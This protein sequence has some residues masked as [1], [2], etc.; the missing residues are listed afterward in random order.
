MEDHRITDLLK[1]VKNQEGRS[2]FDHF[3][4]LFYE[5]NYEP[6]HFYKDPMFFEKLSQFIKKYGFS[7]TNPKTSEEVNQLLST[8]QRK[9]P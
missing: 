2:L 7:Y 5:Y 3:C 8:P 9:V 4:D 1:T 6:N